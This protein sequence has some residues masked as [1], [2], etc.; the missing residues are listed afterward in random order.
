MKSMHRYYR[1]NKKDTNKKRWKVSFQRK[2]PENR[3]KFATK[4]VY[5]VFKNKTKNNQT[6]CGI[7]EVKDKRK[8]WGGG[9]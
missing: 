8:Q 6:Y 7:Q 2:S 9:E 4:N 5:T 1:K 3:R